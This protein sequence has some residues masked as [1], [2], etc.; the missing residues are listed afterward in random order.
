MPFGKPERI[1]LD[2]GGPG[3]TGTEWGKLRHVFGWQFIKAPTRASYQNGLAERSVR[4]LKAATQS[5]ALNDGILNL[6]QEVITLP[7]I[8]KNRSPRAVTG[9]PPAFA[10]TGRC[11]VTI[12]ATTCMWEHDPL[13]RD[14]LIP[15]T[16]ALGEI[17]EAR[18]AILRADSENA[19]RLCLTHNLPG[20][21]GEFPHRGIGANCR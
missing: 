16:N 12:G 11:D 3:P 17:M 6:T 1:I 13:S 10:M 20:G 2:Q 7:A 18:N 21:K 8:A 14:S 15:Q 5:I 4:S 9:L 19:V